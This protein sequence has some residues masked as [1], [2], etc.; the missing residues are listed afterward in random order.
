MPFFNWLKPK[1]ES[2]G[3]ARVPEKTAVE[4]QNASQ[5]E[6]P[7]ASVP[8]HLIVVQLGAFF[9]QLPK[10]MLVKRQV[11]LRRSVPILKEDLYVDE[12]SRIAAVPLSIL[13][14]SCP[15]IFSRPVSSEDDKPIT[16]S[17][18][19]EAP[20]TFETEADPDK[21]PLDS[22]S[23]ISPSEPAM[24]I[25]TEPSVVQVKPQPATKESTTAPGAEEELADSIIRISLKSIL[26]NFPAEYET[27]AIL[28]AGN[29]NAAIKIPL[30]L[31]EPQLASGSVRLS[32]ESFRELVPTELR[33]RFEQ[34]ESGTKISIPLQEIIKQLPPGTIR[35]RVDQQAEHSTESITTPFTEHA[36]EDGIRFGKIEKPEPL[37]VP[38]PAAPVAAIQEPEKPISPAQVPQGVPKIVN[39]ERLQSIFMTDESLDLAGVIEQ[40]RKLPGLRESLL[41]DREG[42]TIAGELSGLEEP[43][44]ISKLLPLVF[45]EVDRQFAGLKFT[46]LET[47]TFCCGHHQLSTFLRDKYSLTVLHDNRPFKPGVREKIQTVLSEIA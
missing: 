32:I 3:G 25:E 34:I 18:N 14:L 10:E 24:P 38:T 40:I 13:S 16:F 46:P 27:P 7:V 45:Q 4:P 19:F 23:A 9:D 33:D 1:S 43:A 35:P 31:V 29:T 21:L 8:E 12:T 15:E 42:R 37:K 36:R 28:D 47:I 5:K 44:A 20:A 2:R 41:T 11:D 26:Q 6:A 39:L 17:L 22:G 30:S